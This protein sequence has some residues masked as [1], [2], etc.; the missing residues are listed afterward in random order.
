[1]R[2]NK[3]K[4]SKH[5]L[6]CSTHFKESCFVVRPGKRGRLLKEDAAPTEFPE[7]NRVSKPER[8]PPKKR[9]LHE[10][11]P[12]PSPPKVRKVMQLDHAY[13]TDKKTLLQENEKLRKKIKKLNQ[14]VRRRNRKIEDMEQ[15]LYILKARNLVA[16]EQHLLLTENFGNMAKEIFDNQIQAAKKKNRHSHRYSDEIKQ[17]ALTLHC[18]SPKAYGFVCKILAL[19]HPSSIR[20]WGASVD[21]SPGFLTNVIDMLGLLLSNLASTFSIMLMAIS[22]NIT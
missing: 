3:W 22:L 18:Y 4:P 9:V 15:L 6:L 11:I 5:S 19:P 2:R 1:M 14:K 21:C 13:E 7:I 10:P 8:K 16:S 12:P 20:A 17:F